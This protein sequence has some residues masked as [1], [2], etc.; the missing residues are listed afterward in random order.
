MENVGLRFFAGLIHGFRDEV[1]LF[2]EFLDLLELLLH[3]L[4]ATIVAHLL[5]LVVA[6]EVVHLVSAFG[7]LVPDLPLRID[8]LPGNKHSVLSLPMV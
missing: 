5:M 3:G 2:L 1:R 7:G 6:L 4:L 8:L